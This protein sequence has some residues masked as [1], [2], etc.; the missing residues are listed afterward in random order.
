MET[1]LRVGFVYFFLMISLRLLGKREFGELSPFDLVVLLMIPELVSQAL[2]REDFSMTNAV[3]GVAT[4]LTLVWF[5]SVAAYRSERLGTLINGAP[6]VLVQHGFLVPEAL[7]HERI[8][9]GQ[10]LEAMH[11]AGLERMEQVKWA[12][13]GSDGKIAVVPWV[14]EGSGHPQG[15]EKATL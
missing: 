12:I 10:V 8:T 1:V 2:V 13:L 5:T 11:S 9:P 4:L 6:V 14:Q 15:E 7:N 3:I